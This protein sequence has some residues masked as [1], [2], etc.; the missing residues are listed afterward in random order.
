MTVR[1]LDAAVNGRLTPQLILFLTIAHLTTWGL[2]MA[3]YALVPARNMLGTHHA[4]VYSGLYVLVCSAASLV[5]VKLWERSRGTCAEDAGSGLLEVLGNPALVTA[6]CMLSVIG[7]GLHY[8]DKLIINH[9]SGACLADL[10]GAWIDATVARGRTLSSWQSALGHILSHATFPLLFALFIGGQRLSRRLRL[11]GWSVAVCSTL[12]YSVIIGTRTTILSF[13]ACA[14]L[15]VGLGLCLHRNEHVMSEAKRSLKALALVLAMALSYAAAISADR[16]Y[17]HGG[18]NLYVDQFVPELSAEFAGPMPESPLGRL[19]MLIGIY[20]S[21]SS[22]TFE[23]S[24]E[25]PDRSGSVFLNF[26]YY[27]LYKL[28]VLDAM[29]SGERPYQHGMMSLTGA[30]WYDFDLAGMLVVAILHGIV[31]A[32][33][34]VLLSTTGLRQALGALTYVCI[35]LIT[36]WA[37]L[38]FA[39]NTLSYPFIGLAFLA[40]I[41]CA[42]GASTLVGSFDWVM[43][44]AGRRD[45]RYAIKADFTPS[46]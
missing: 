34:G 1:A 26:G 36:L 23:K 19:A 14:V 2:H 18:P 41:S 33:A 13:V 44:P 17:C 3:A 39:P 5:A 10:R 9:F 16:M 28:G 45:E 8:Y 43:V 4:L 27:W 15:A 40:Y 12:L 42:W 11:T 25:F 22:W 20:V 7:L 35:G 32:Y 21:H 6:F 31:I 29:P 30:A 24:L 38:A 37:P 46:G